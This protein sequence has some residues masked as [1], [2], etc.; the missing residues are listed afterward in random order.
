MGM[1]LEDIFLKL[2]TEDHESLQEAE[3]LAHEH[4]FQATA[5]EETAEA[6]EV[7]KGGEPQ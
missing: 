7:E 6:E 5:D 3:A 4:Q 2:T 1:S